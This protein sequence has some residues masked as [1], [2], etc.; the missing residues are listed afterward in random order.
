MALSSAARIRWILV[1]ILLAGIAGAW[2]MRRRPATYPVAYVGDRTAVI[3]STTAQVRQTVATLHYGERV[4]VLRRTAEQSQVRT[5]DGIQ[6]WLDNRLLMDPALWKKSADLLASV[7]AMPV[8]ASGRTRA[9][10]NVHLEP[11]RGTPRIFQFGRNVPVVVFERRT[12]P[13]ADSSPSTS[14]DNGTADEEATK[15]DQEKS[16][17]DEGKDKKED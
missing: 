15:P 11:G 6:G 12:A 3:W 14:A 1:I 2:W 10:S 9:F 8:Q 17:E 13:V 5:D 7:R 16:A 4:A